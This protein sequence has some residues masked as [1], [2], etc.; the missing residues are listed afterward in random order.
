MKLLLHWKCNYVKIMYAY[1]QG[2]EED[3]EKMKTVDLQGVAGL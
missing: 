3:E 2:L 1:G